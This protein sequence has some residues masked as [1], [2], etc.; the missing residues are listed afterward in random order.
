MPSV[1]APA[2]APTRP[3]SATA[4]WRTCPNSSSAAR[5]RPSCSTV[6]T[7]TSCPRR[8]RR[9]HD[10]VVGTVEHEGR[11]RAAL[12]EL[13]HVLHGAVAEG[14]L[15]GAPAGAQTLG[16]GERFGHEVDGGGVEVPRRGPQSLPVHGGH[17]GASARRGVE[18]GEERLR[19]GALPEEVVGGLTGG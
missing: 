18:L 3:P 17:P 15:V 1:C 4:P 16:I 5:Y 14:G 6:P 7:T 2:G 13:G 8:E 11:Y 19:L 9:R 10:V 12:E